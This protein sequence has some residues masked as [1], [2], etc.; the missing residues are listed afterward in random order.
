MTMY[1]R[2]KHNLNTTPF[3]IK[4]L[5]SILFVF[6]LARAIIAIQQL[7]AHLSGFQQQVMAL[8]QLDFFLLIICLPLTLGL[9][10]LVKKS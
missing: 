1:Q 7:Q 10:Y 4:A 6:C 2:I 3:S 5:F 9:L 8:E